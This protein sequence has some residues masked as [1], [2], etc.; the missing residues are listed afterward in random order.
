M[1]PHPP[2]VA[3]RL[4]SDIFAA[5]GVVRPA[6]LPRVPAED[7]FERSVDGLSGL[8]RRSGYADVVGSEVSWIHSTSPEAWWNGAAAGIGATGAVLT[9][10]DSATRGR[11]RLHFDKLTAPFVGGDGLLSLPTSAVLVSGRVR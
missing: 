1:W 4:W 11:V 10:Q 6:D 2:P 8:L 3:Q 9:A 7:D 5:A